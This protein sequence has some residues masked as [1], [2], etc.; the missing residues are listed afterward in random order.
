MREERT[1]EKTRRDGPA[2]QCRN[3]VRAAAASRPLLMELVVLA[4]ALGE[5]PLR[6]ALGKALIVRP[7]KKR[8]TRRRRQ[9]KPDLTSL[10]RLPL[11][12]PW[13]VYD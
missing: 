13:L 1:Y 12:Y 11:F 9:L 10:R 5:E 2:I 4:Q 6:K 7:L 8:A 3:L